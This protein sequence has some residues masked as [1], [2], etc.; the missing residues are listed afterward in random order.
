MNS[1][2]I[3]LQEEEQRKHKRMHI[4][5]SYFDKKNTPLTKLQSITQQEIKQECDN[6]ENLNIPWV[7]NDWPIKCSRK[8]KSESY[9]SLSF[10]LVT[11]YCIICIKCCLLCFILPYRLRKCMYKHNKIYYQYLL[12]IV[13]SGI[14]FNRILVI[15][16]EISSV[17]FPM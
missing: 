1:K 16:S 3:E 6:M 10:L 9:D 14:K 7:E 4:R 8:R 13:L 12:C 5:R 2:K 11:L 15:L 17:P